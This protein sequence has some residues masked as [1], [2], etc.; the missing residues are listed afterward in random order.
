MAKKIV[1]MGTPQ[2]SVQTLKKLVQSKYEIEATPTLIINE[3][4]FKG[5]IKELEKYLDKLL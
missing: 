3:K 1:F 4:K 5:S 2:F